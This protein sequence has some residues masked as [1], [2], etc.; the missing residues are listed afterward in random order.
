MCF[1]ITLIDD[2]LITGRRFFLL[3]LMDLR[4]GEIIETAAVTIND[5]DGTFNIATVSISLYTL[6]FYIICN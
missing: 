5:N 4:W 1:D 3:A 2:N 6:I